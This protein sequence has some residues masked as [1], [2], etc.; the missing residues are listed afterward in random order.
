V[1]LRLID[2]KTATPKQIR[3]NVAAVERL[4]N[5][6]DALVTGRVIALQRRVVPTAQ[7]YVAALRDGR[8]ERAI[9]LEATLRTKAVPIAATCGLQPAQVYGLPANR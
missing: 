1:Q 8:H 6:A 7:L 4:A 2:A 9:A 5:T 3:D